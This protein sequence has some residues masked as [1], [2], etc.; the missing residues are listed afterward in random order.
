MAIFASA[1]AFR[2][3]FRQGAGFRRSLGAVKRTPFSSLVFAWFLLKKRRSFPGLAGRGAG[4]LGAPV[5]IPRGCGSPVFARRATVVG[6]AKTRKR[7]CRGCFSGNV[8][9]IKF[10]ATP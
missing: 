3:P 5:S 9:T 8:R 1:Y 7:E 10:A 2:R 6:F 4:Q